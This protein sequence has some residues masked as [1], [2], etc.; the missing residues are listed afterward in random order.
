MT[1]N[2]TTSVETPVRRIS[3]VGNLTREPMLRYSAS[4]TAW[5]S[6]GL[7]VNRRK[8]KDDGTFEDLPPEFY[9]LVCF[10][11]LAERVAESLKKGDRVVVVGRLEEDHY[12]A[13]DGTERTTAKLVADDIGASL[14][15]ATLNVERVRRTTPPEPEPEG[16]GYSEEPF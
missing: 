7:A 9:D 3:Q 12:T 11:D 16:Y 10:G 15:F 1:S 5:V 6:S 2:T 4:G 13:R 14:R 8:R